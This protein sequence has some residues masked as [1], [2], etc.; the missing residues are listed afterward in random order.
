MTRAKR[1]HIYRPPVVAIGRTVTVSDD[2][3]HNRS[4]STQG[5]GMHL[6]FDFDGTT[7]DSARVPSPRN[8]E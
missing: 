3:L 1:R 8:R 7:T 4:C 5:S 6:L 2:Y